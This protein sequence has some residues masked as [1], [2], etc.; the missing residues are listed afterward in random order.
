MWDRT[1]YLNLLTYLNYP[2]FV[3]LLK[4][5]CDGGQSQPV[6]YRMSVKD[7]VYNGLFIPAGA[8]VHAN[9]W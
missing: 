5:C 1:D 8:N 7:D 3:L 2:Q 6:A 4:K 9:Q